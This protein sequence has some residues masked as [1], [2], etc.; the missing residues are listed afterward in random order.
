MVI[1]SEASN[2]KFKTN[3]ELWVDPN[4]DFI[5]EITELIGEGNIG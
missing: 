3:S 5:N 1:T 4:D 2:R